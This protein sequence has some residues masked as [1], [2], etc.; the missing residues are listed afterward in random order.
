MLVGTKADL[1]EDPAENLIK[2]H[3]SKG[4]NVLSYIECSAIEK[5]KL[6]NIFEEAIQDYFKDKR[7]IREGVDD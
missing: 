6:E 1:R 7:S 3:R 4:V 5:K 2:E